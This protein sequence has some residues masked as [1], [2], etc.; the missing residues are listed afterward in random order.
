MLG[1]DGI[2]HIGLRASNLE[3]CRKFYREILGLKDESREPGIVRI[4]AGKDNIILYEP[5]AGISDIHFGF[6][7]ETNSQVDEWREWLRQNNVAIYEDITEGD[8]HRSIKVR[9]PAGHW[10]EISQER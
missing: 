2:R 7:V 10:I 3:E 6:R 1:R 4:Q 5:H 9:D 8:K